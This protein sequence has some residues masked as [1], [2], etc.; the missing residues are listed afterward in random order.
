MS[1]KVSVFKNEQFQFYP[2]ISIGPDPRPHTHTI[3]TVSSKITKILNTVFLSFFISA[4]TKVLITFGVGTASTPGFFL[5]I[6][7]LSQS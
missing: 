2:K 1:A 7:N 6:P 3:K 4:D 5:S